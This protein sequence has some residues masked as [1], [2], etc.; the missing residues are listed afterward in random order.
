MIFL[1]G[2]FLNDKNPFVADPILSLLTGGVSPGICYRLYTEY[3]NTSYATPH[4]IIQTIPFKV[5]WWGDFSLYHRS[6]DGVLSY[7]CADCAALFR[8][9]CDFGLNEMDLIGKSLIEQ[10][11]Q[12][13]AGSKCY[14]LQFLS[15]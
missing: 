10:N 3:R 4:Q 2:P 11:S 9:I 14:N 8:P 15:V 1:E 13:V 5:F 7:C 12:I 6:K